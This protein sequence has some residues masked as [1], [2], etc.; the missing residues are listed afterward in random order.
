MPAA[1]PLMSPETARDIHDISVTLKMI[2]AQQM[3]RPGI[4]FGEAL[5]QLFESDRDHGVLYNRVSAW[6][7]NSRQCG[8]G[9]ADL[10]A[11]A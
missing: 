11:V 8:T 3:T 9:P 2:L 1:R 7:D 5:N 10:T 4:P 6:T